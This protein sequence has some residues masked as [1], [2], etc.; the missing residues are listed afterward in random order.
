MQKANF[1][2]AKPPREACGVAAEFRQTKAN[3]R[4]AEF[5]EANPP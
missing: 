1:G 2:E 3:G 5:R 4:S